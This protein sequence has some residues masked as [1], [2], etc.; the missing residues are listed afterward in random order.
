MGCSISGPPAESRGRYSLSRCM[1]RTAGS[2]FCFFCVFR[3]F[4]ILAVVFL[5]RS[6]RS[7][8]ATSTPIYIYHKHIFAFL[9]KVQQRFSC[10]V[11]IPTPHTAKTRTMPTFFFAIHSGIHTYIAV[12]M[13]VPPYIGYV[14]SVPPLTHT[15]LSRYCNPSFLPSLL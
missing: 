3:V 12:F 7:H 10:A 11:L 2:C 4:Y 5:D 9:A 13:I 6:A 15:P 1:I 8:A 14:L